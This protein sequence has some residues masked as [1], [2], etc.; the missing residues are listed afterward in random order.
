M[1]NKQILK[2]P[3]VMIYWIDKHFKIILL[4]YVKLTRDFDGLGRSI[5]KKQTLKRNISQDKKNTLLINSLML[6]KWEK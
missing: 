4:N 1:I 6:R 2:R 3:W 5:V